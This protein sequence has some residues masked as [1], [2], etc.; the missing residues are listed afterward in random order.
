MASKGKR[1]R[2]RWLRI[3]AVLLLLLALLVSL[4]PKF[5]ATDFVRSKL[6]TALAQ[7][8]DRRVTIGSVHA[9]WTGGIEVRG[10]KIKNDN[11]Q[12]AEESL[13]EIES[14]RIEQP[15]W[16]LPGDEP[17]H[18]VLDRPV[19]RL[20][21]QAGLTNFDEWHA[22]LTKRFEPRPAPPPEPREPPRTAYI[23]IKDGAV[24]L[25]R[26]MP[27]PVGGPR[28]LEPGE[29]SALFGLDRLNLDIRH[30]ARGLRIDLDASIVAAEERGHVKASLVPGTDELTIDAAIPMR[31]LDAILTKTG[32][33]GQLRIEAAGAKHDRGVR[34]E[35]KLNLL[36]FHLPFDVEGVPAEAEATWNVTIDRGTVLLESLRV[37]AEQST[38][39]L[40]GQL[41]RSTDAF[42]IGGSARLDLAR[43]WQLLGDL[44]GLDDANIGSGIAYLEDLNVAYGGPDDVSASLFVRVSGLEATGFTETPVVA[45]EA[46]L[47]VEAS[48]DG[49]KV[50]LNE[51]T[52]GDLQ[53][54][55]EATREG[56]AVRWKEAN[57]QGKVELTPLLLE[58][59]GI[60]PAERPI[61]GTASIRANLARN[62]DGTPAIRLWTRVRELEVAI[63]N[64]RG[65]WSGP[66]DV[67]FD[68]N[69]SLT[70]W[71]ARPEHLTGNATL[72]LPA[73]DG[74]DALFTAEAVDIKL[75]DQRATAGFSIHTTDLAQIRAL[76]RPFVA[77]ALPD[78]AGDV[79]VTG[80]CELR[81]PEWPARV[82]VFDHGE[83]QIQSKELIFRDDD[84]ERFRGRL[85]F[86]SGFRRKD[87]GSAQLWIEGTSLTL[88]EG[89][90]RIEIR[91]GYASLPLDRNTEDRADGAADVAITVERKYLSRFVD[92]LKETWPD[93]VLRASAHVQ[94][95]DPTGTDKSRDGRVAV[96]AK[97]STDQLLLILGATDRIES[98]LARIDVQASASREL[99]RQVFLGLPASTEHRER[100]TVELHHFEAKLDTVELELNGQIRDVRKRPNLQ[101]N[102]S[103]EANGFDWTLMDSD[104]RIPQR[105]VAI[106]RITESVPENGED[107]EVHFSL[108]GQ[109]EIEEA[110]YDI[111]DVFGGSGDVHLHGK[112]SPYFYRWNRE[113]DL[114]AKKIVFDG[115]A[116]EQVTLRESVRSEDKPGGRYHSRS[117]IVLTVRET[118]IG[119]EKLARIQFNGTANLNEM[120]HV[121]TTPPNV[122]GRLEVGGV[123]LLRG[124]STNLEF[125]GD[126]VSFEQ[127]DA[128]I[129]QGRMTGSATLELPG[130]VD[131]NKPPIEK[132]KW[133]INLRLQDVAIF[134]GLGDSVRYVVPIVH[135]GPEIDSK[136]TGKFAGNIRLH[137]EGFSSA[138]LKRSLG[139]EGELHLRDFVVTGSP[140]LKVL[141][142]QMRHLFSG[143][144]Y[145]FERADG[146]FEIKDGKVRILDELS[147]QG[148][149]KLRLTGYATLGGRLDF[150]IR[151]NRLIPL[152]LKG[153]FDDPKVRVKRILPRPFR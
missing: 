12:F 47:R 8:L 152:T 79:V 141:T 96:D 78:F 122:T 120:M 85:E 67:I 92:G 112:R 127:F 44:T 59:A 36:D 98:K 20:E 101:A 11:V 9:S 71:P 75:D 39:N 41:D 30:D 37:S 1:W 149:M 145:N 40:M 28:I 146:R 60:D 66:H 139:G 33:T 147:I 18:I 130:S 99:L 90:N 34:I 94:V 53:L 140:V 27:R 116:I 16:T 23:K 104:L 3:G 5:A 106:G 119:K 137:G 22:A 4:A 107:G 62:P 48:I 151:H 114:K 58:L 100:E 89:D 88:S 131:G 77:D 15:L 134:K 69:L 142:L 80:S 128:G 135:R 25:R 7:S 110:H 32:T 46:A 105:I 10:L 35:G 132:E 124:I 117:G 126:K 13:I 87:E 14:A 6:V 42:T 72:R 86:E 148:P 82:L 125:T 70:G 81:A 138:D 73:P 153:T 111:V 143:S 17:L 103:A 38:V 57:L 64:E 49:K 19:I 150:V 118:L 31:L 84:G 113:L 29:A 129:N 43:A 26:A 109:L 91:N 21:E 56:D 83:V 61:K 63:P 50:I 54:S 115:Q 121:S 93:G 74:T 136:L 123:H 55:G 2:R 51:L 52:F 68:A 133:R 76:A 144:K 45:S 108:T 95:A 97:V 102:V 65:K 24:T